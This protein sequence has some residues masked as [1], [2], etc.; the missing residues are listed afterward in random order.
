MTKLTDI[1]R[2]PIKS[3]SRE[4]LSQVVLKAG[5][6]MPMDRKWAVAHEAAK[7]EPGAWARCSNF[8]RG[9]KAPEL[10]A[11]D[12]VWD[13][14]T[15]EISVTHPSL[16]TRRFA[17]DDPAQAAA[18]IDWIKPLNPADRAQPE[19]LV[20]APGLAFTDHPDQTVSIVN[21]AS[22]RAFNDKRGVT[23][24]PRRFR[25]NLWLDEGLAPWAEFDWVGK[26]IAI[27]SVEI[28]IV[29]RVERCR[30]TE[31]NPQTGKVDFPTQAAL[32]EDW[33]HK[34]FGVHGIVRRGGTIALGDLLRA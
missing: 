22:L 14:A 31:A 3:H 27:G 15:S 13:D 2:H 26:T 17:P 4:Q 10:M 9:A 16:G 20:T 6:A 1:W 7:L 23:L 24:D 5:Q 19:K 30:A 8:A 12:A 11:L 21:H 33:G 28:E 18:F 32:I 29:E 34:D 25:I